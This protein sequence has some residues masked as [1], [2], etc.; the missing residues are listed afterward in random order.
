M[1]K[2]ANKY[3]DAVLYVVLTTEIHN[4]ISDTLENG[5][6]SKKD[7]IKKVNSSAEHMLKRLK[8]VWP[9]CISI[10]DLNEAKKTL[11]AKVH[12]KYVGHFGVV[13]YC[14]VSRELDNLKELIR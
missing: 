8:K 11:R 14:E 9:K 13:N 10:A 12:K 4:L 1:A 5:K 6:L 2:K 7:M 3:P